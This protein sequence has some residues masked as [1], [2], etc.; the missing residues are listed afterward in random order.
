LQSETSFSI[1]SATDTSGHNL[2][3]D[4]VCA[5]VAADASRE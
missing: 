5:S 1:S 2:R 4:V 3:F